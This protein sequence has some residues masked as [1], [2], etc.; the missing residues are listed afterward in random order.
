[1]TNYFTALSER[2]LDG[3]ASTLHFPFA[4]SEDIEPIVVDR[5]ADLIAAPPPS[6]SLTGKGKSR[7][8][9]GSYDLLESMNVCLYCPVVGVFTLSFARFTPNGHKAMVRPSDRA[10][11][12]RVV[13][14]AAGARRV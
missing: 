9:P 14:C 12:A 13:R 7:L 2:N 1:V 11:P 3:I 8:M 5:V 10:M 4:L 6:L